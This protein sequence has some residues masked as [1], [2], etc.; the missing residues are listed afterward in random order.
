[1]GERRLARVVLAGV[2]GAAGLAA[3]SDRGPGAGEARLEVD[4]EAVVTRADGDR[5]VVTGRTDV[6]AGD[7][8][9]VVEGRA[10]MALAGGHRLELRDG[11]GDDA[12]TVVRMGPVPELEAG[13]LLVASPDAVE[14]R[15]AGTLVEVQEGAAK[16]SR[17]LGMSVASYDAE[18]V[19]D[20]AGQERAVPALR[21]LL[22]PALGS[23]Q[24]L[25]PAVCKGASSTVTACP[26][27]DPTDSW[28]RRYLGDAMDLGQRL[29]SIADAYTSSLQPG[30]GR[31]PGFFRLILPA[32]DEEDEFTAE[33]LDADRAPGD[34]LVGAAITELG[35]E[36][37]F[38]ERWR[39]VFAFRD[40]GAEWG[41]VA[42]D[43]A[44]S[45]TPLLGAVTEA[46]A[47]SPLA[48]APTATGATSGPSPSPP[49][50]GLADP[51]PTSPTTPPGGP[52]SPAPSPTAAPP[53]APSPTTPP[54][55]PPPTTVPESPL[56]PVL[57]PIVEP[58]TD[59]TGGLLDAAGGLLQP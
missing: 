44:V 29:E 1:M 56:T 18:V 57:Q 6:G 22:V 43:Q 53:P 51:G 26:A 54:P 25:R 47:A 20:S 9:E 35:E 59:L 30:E 21:A 45:R 38:R 13:D 15:A 14:V 2:V 32:L 49:P 19:V 36:G 55:T 58:V 12:D 23:P 4:G 33:L 50:G 5:D 34:T 39:S 46:I 3:C 27:Y 28:D 40:E 37:R 31:T 17:T 8:V 16:V 42:L 7:R 24:P 41:L 11:H 52:G 10:T 48:F